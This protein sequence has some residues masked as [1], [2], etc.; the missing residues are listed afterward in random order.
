MNRL[1]SHNRRGFFVLLIA[2]PSLFLWSCSLSPGSERAAIWNEWSSQEGAFQLTGYQSLE[3]LMCLTTETLGQFAMPAAAMAA[4]GAMLRSQRS[5][6]S[7]DIGGDIA[8]IRVVRD[9][10]PVVAYL[11]VDP[12]N[13]LVVMSDENLFGLRAYDRVHKQTGLAEPRFTISGPKTHMEFICGV[14]V[15]PVRR[16]IYTVNNDTLARMVVF[17]YDQRGNVAPVRELKSGKAWGIFLDQE[18]DEVVLANQHNNK[19]LIYRRAA[20]DDE[21]PVRLIQGPKTGLADPHG[22]YVDAKNNEMVVT[23]YGSW[24]PERTGEEYE[25]ISERLQQPFFYPVVP[26]GGKFELPSIRVFGRTADGDAVPLRT[27]QGMRTRL[28]LP[29]GVWVDTERDEILVAN[30]GEN[31]IL[32]F[33]RKAEGDVAPIRTIEGPDTRL[34]NPTAVVV[35]IENDEIWV[36]N[37][38]DHAA[39]VYPRSASGNV[40]P[41]RTIRTAPNGAPVPGM[42]NPSAVAYDPKRDQI[43][44]PN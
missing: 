8:P 19:I 13:D 16:E 10:Y 34:K 23:N 35:D 36:S 3:G 18:N 33:D 25:R 41:L 21:E 44:V 12:T 20:A 40:E 38:G 17:S 5:S 32:V 24:H 27:I 26:S 14:A 7:A 4:R 9:P 37:W 29:A 28:N 42:G 22:V 11:A 31:A 1:N 6:S 2:V 39:T 43:L 30:D 15:D